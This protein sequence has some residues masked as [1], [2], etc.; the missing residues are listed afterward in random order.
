M[1]DDHTVVMWKTTCCSDGRQNSNTLATTSSL[2]D[3]YSSFYRPRIKRKKPVTTPSG[4]PS[5]DKESQAEGKR[6]N[7]SAINL[8]L[9]IGTKRL[10]IWI[11]LEDPA[12]FSSKRLLEGWGGFRKWPA[13]GFQAL[14]DDIM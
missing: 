13:E 11:A 1:T 4:A 5:A 12:D 10:T 3:K 2:G 8:Q 7:N 9:Q 14:H 6:K